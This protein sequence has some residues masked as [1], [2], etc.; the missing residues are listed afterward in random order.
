LS[1]VWGLSQKLVRSKSNINELG[2]KGALALENVSV[3]IADAMTLA[4]KL[5]FTYKWCDALCIVHDDE[6]D[7]GICLAAMASIYRVALLHMLLLLL[8][9][10]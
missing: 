3:T 2:K 7:K 8:L 5:G 4:D 1:Y 9:Q 10:G 6:S